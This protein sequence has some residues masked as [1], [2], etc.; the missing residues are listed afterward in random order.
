MIEEQ[1]QLLIVIISAI[2]SISAIMLKSFVTINFQ[3]LWH[4]GLKIVLLLSIGRVLSYSLE[5][6]LTALPNSLIIVKI[7]IVAI[8]ILIVFLSQDRIALE[9]VSDKYRLPKKNIKVVFIQKV[10]KIV[11]LGEKEFEEN[12]YTKA[13]YGTLHV[14]D[15]NSV[16]DDVNFKEMLQS[17]NKYI[18][19]LNSLE[20]SRVDFL[21]EELLETVEAS[22]KL[23]EFQSSLEDRNELYIKIMKLIGR[24]QRYFSVMKMMNTGIAVDCFWLIFFSVLLNQI[25][26]AGS[27]FELLYYVFLSAFGSVRIFEWLDRNLVVVKVVNEMQNGYDEIKLY[28]ARYVNLGV[29]GW[30]LLNG[31]KVMINKDRVV[32][33]TLENFESP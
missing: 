6:A 2:A 32:S 1:V 10:S 30:D 9:F 15:T 19:E 28:N 20:F 13:F 26:M 14:E 22:E 27:L 24:L 11:D 33:L 29:S 4:Y 16:L 18:E 25:T 21:T 17:V 12:T 23:L 8:M 3:Y 31:N 7:I 5:A